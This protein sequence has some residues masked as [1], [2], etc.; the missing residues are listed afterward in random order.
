MYPKRR[1]K[2][3][4]CDAVYQAILNAQK[5]M[6]RLEI[7]QA[8]GMA[9]SPSVIAMI[10]HLVAINFVYKTSAVDKWGRSAWFY[11]ASVDVIEGITSA[12]ADVA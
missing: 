2:Q 5:P 7:A 10:E 4:L 12:C 3:E 6:T 11:T 1:T 9:K 8:I